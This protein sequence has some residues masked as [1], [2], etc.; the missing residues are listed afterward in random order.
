MRL[1]RD[2]TDRTLEQPG[3]VLT[4]SDLRESARPAGEIDIGGDRPR[5]P[6]GPPCLT[7][8]AV[9]AGASRARDRVQQRGCDV[10]SFCRRGISQRPRST[11][12]PRNGNRRC[13]RRCDRSA[14]HDHRQ[15]RDQFH[16]TH[17]T[18]RTRTRDSDASPGLR[19][20][21][22]YHELHGSSGRNVTAFDG[23]S[24]MVMARTTAFSSAT[25]AASSRQNHSARFSADGLDC[26]NGGTSLMQP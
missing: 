22:R 26:V 17:G 7:Q 16:T 2:Q 1:R 11:L 21:A 10:L 24:Q 9:A 14:R 3:A 6:T 18:R 19:L 4:A 15:D 12:I 25:A 5:A 23:P 20:G 8:G 13:R